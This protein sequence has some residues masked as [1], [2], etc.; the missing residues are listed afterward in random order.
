MTKPSESTKDF[1]WLRSIRT[2]KHDGYLSDEDCWRIQEY[3]NHPSREPVW[4]EKRQLPDKPIKMYTEEY[5]LGRNCG[6]N[7]AIKAYEEARRR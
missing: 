5:Y 7:E 4:P 1:M 3:F 6:I 2:I